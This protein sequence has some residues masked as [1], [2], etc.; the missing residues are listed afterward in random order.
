M[1]ENYPLLSVSLTVLSP[2]GE[3]V[4]NYETV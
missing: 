4:C 3:I 2:H 1:E